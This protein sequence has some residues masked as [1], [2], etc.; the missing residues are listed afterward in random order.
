M[1]LFKTIQVDQE[2]SEIALLRDD[3]VMVLA[4]TTKQLLVLNTEN[5]QTELNRIDYAISDMKVVDD[6]IVAR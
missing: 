2:I 4:L 5:G 1:P 3:N 6:F